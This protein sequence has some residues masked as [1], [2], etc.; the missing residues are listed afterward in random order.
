MSDQPQPGSDST[1]HSVPESPVLLITAWHLRRVR[2]MP[3]GFFHV[4]RLDLA[5]RAEAGC[6]W[7]H[8][9]I[10]LRSVMLT[11]RWESEEGAR[12]WL[13]GASF[14]R[15][16]AALRSIEGTVPRVEQYRPQ[17]TLDSR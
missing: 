15:T 8:R 9:W 10:S 3:K 13:R 5:T 2:S 17:A 7:V 16:D 4:R 1:G 14:T 12:R 6:L 11:S